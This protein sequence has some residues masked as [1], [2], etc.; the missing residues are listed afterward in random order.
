MD[1]G[2]AVNEA[3]TGLPEEPLP[4]DEGAVVPPIGVGGGG[5]GTFLSHPASSA[6]PTSAQERLTHF[7]D[8]IFMIT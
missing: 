2:S 1:E 4:E 8:S 3:T 7:V 6:I 5:I